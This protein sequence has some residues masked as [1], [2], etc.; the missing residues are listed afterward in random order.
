MAKDWIISERYET[1][2]LE[3]GKP[4]PATWP[5]LK[6]V[7]WLFLLSRL[8]FFETAGLAYIYLPHA[9]VETPPGRLPPSG[10]FFYHILAGLWVHWDGLWYLSIANVGYANRPQATAFFP[11]Y[12]LV[13]KL[14]GG[15]VVSGML[16]SMACFLVALYV[17][18]RLVTLDM[19]PR[20]AWFSILALAVFPTSFYFNAVYSES[21]F[22]LLAVSSLYSLRTGRY[23]I[24]GI[25]GALATLTST[26]GMVLCLP[27]LWV[28]WR[29]HGFRIKRLVHILWM[30]AG[31]VSYMIFL[32]PRFGDPL[33][34]EKV[35][36]FWGR[37]FELFPVTI[38]DAFK[39]AYHA[40]P[41]FFNPHQLFAT[42][43][44]TTTA[45]NFFNL[46][47]GIFAIVIAIVSAKRIPFYLW[48]YMLGALLLPFTY[49][50]GDPLMSIP[51]LTLEAF[52][53][54]IG[55]GSIMARIHWTRALY[56]IVAIPS[57]MLLTALFAT[58]HWVA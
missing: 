30:P 56:F 2:V 26:Y 51:R 47:F 22:L 53:I 8:F 12:P 1:P 27:F 40:L 45:S 58:A 29:S 7:V 54:F 3:P 16:V 33:V 23:W 35:Q 24:A 55:I 10:N 44:P 41:I 5:W 4:S 46:L 42:G 15:G 21:L 48:L 39:S 31:L 9:W 36:K 32:I 38:F 18:A 25:L 17:F 49:P 6:N 43:V 52:P 57:G 34:F 14:F 19:G 28:I 20:V 37:H 13:M 50:A 11:L